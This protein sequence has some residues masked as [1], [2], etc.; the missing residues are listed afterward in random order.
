MNPRVRRNLSGSN[1]TSPTNSLSVPFAALLVNSNWNNLSL[2]LGSKVANKI[3]ITVITSQW[4]VKEREEQRGA[5]LQCI[6]YQTSQERKRNNR[7]GCSLPILCMDKSLSEDCIVYSLCIDVRV[8]P[9]ISYDF[10]WLAHSCQC[11]A[12]RNRGNPGL[13]NSEHDLLANCMKRLH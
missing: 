3:N 2:K 5:M 7:G 9:V 11:Q 1:A 12:A 6:C 13:G 4:C 8:A 10:H